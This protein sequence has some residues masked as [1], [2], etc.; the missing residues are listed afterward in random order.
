MFPEIVV[1]GYVSQD[2]VEG[3]RGFRQVLGG[4]GTYSAVA[5][6]VCKANVGLV[7]RIGDDFNPVHLKNLEKVGVDIKGIKGIPNEKSSK[8]V[9]THEKSK[10]KHL[11]YGVN[12]GFSISVED[13]PKKYLNASVYHLCSLSPDQ[14]FAFIKFLQEVNPYAYISVDT[15]LEEMARS[16]RVFF[17]DVLANSDFFFPNKFEAHEAHWKIRGKRED[18]LN[19]IGRSLARIVNEFVVI[20]DAENGASY[21]DKNKEFHLPSYP[22]KVVELTGAGDTFVGGFLT[23]FLKEKNPKECVA[24]GNAVASFVIEDYGMERLFEIQNKHVEA[25][26]QHILRY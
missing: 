1:V 5:A 7:S 13:L 10:V 25:R 8:W 14:Q 6:A 9:I 15:K 2:L 23:S 12:V 22:A 24:L 3:A 17:S 19:E 26:A 4:A 21:F 11:E 16:P 20:K 18:N